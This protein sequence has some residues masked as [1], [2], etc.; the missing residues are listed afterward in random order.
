MKVETRDPNATVP[1]NAP[2]VTL[3]EPPADNPVP[4]IV[5]PGT[6]TS[7]SETTDVVAA[8]HHDD[9]ARRPR[10]RR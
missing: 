10:R 6:T 7:S 1:P 3:P 5:E 9:G 2:P 4:G 8:D